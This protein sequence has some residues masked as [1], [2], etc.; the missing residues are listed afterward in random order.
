MGNPL[1]NDAQLS[2][3]AGRA[4]TRQPGHLVKPTRIVLSSYEIGTPPQN[5][6]TS[7]EHG[8]IAVF[9]LR[10]NSFSSLAP[11]NHCS[12][13]TKACA[14]SVWQW[15]DERCQVQSDMRQRQSTAIQP[16]TICGEELQKKR[17]ELKNFGT[18]V[19]CFRTETMIQATSTTSRS[20]VRF[21]PARGW[22]ASRVM[23]VSVSSATVTTEVCPSWLTCSC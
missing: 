3:T 8:W 13:G 19:N 12:Q 16:S 23:D 17:P 6:K 18:F 15:F 5:M 4:K 7:T 21:S 14:T 1:M 20:K 2:Q 22:L 11:S 9:W 10:R